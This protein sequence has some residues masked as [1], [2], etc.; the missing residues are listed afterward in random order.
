VIG[1]RPVPIG[2]AAI[3]A[4]GWRV[5]RIGVSEAGP[6][7]PPKGAFRAEF[8][9]IYD[10][11]ATRRRRSFW[12]VGLTIELRLFSR[13]SRGATS[14]IRSVP[15][16]RSW[17]RKSGALIRVSFGNCAGLGM[18]AL[19]LNSAKAPGSRHSPGAAVFGPTTVHRLVRLWGDDK[20]NAGRSAS[21]SNLVHS[22]ASRQVRPKTS[23]GAPTKSSFRTCQPSRVPSKNRY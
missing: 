12:R 6:I 22:A 18:F 21:A 9:S 4:C 17:Q 3:L 15:S 20:Y 7:S 16:S 13:R 8:C 10:E 23:K 5:G 2:R 14:R 19:C 1:R 11:R